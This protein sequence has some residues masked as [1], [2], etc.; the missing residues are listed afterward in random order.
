MAMREWRNRNQKFSNAAIIP[1]KS[2]VDEIALFDLPGVFNMW[3]WMECERMW[4]D[5]SQL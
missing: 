1:M 3:E 5:G 4:L 2:I